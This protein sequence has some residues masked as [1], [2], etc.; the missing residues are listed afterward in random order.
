M[1]RMFSALLMTATLAAPMVVPSSALAGEP[2]ARATVTLRVFDPFRRDYHVWDHR[3]ERSY[4]AY[5]AARHRA[6]LS[7]QRQRLA[8][9]RAYWRWRHEREERL[10]HARR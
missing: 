8:E 9:R 2:G 3:E 4:R 5:L 7:Y 10:E 1:R 6:Y